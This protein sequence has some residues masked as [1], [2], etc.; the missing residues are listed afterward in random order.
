MVK[1]SDGRSNLARQVVL[2]GVPIPAFIAGPST[3]GLETIGEPG[4]DRS[5]RIQVM[6]WRNASLTQII[7]RL[8]RQPRRCSTCQA[9]TPVVVN[10]TWSSRY[11]T[12]ALK[13]GFGSIRVASEEE[14]ELRIRYRLISIL[15]QL[16]PSGASRKISFRVTREQMGWIIA[17]KELEAAAVQAIKNLID[18]DEDLLTLIRTQP[19]LKAKAA[20][21]VNYEPAD[22]RSLIQSVTF[23]A[24]RKI[25]E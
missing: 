3:G 7:R 11:V 2:N 19:I 18:G 17:S 1:S 8:I 4:G 16:Y 9:P 6:G 12:T 20:I 10:T 21:D 25:I 13:P 14:R 22:P 5:P 24:Y 23:S 15:D